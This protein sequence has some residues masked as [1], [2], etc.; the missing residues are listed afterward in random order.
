L[1]RHLIGTPEIADSDIPS[2]RSFSPSNTVLALGGITVTFPQSLAL[3]R[4]SPMLALC[5][6]KWD[7]AMGSCFHFELV[8]R[9]LAQKFFAGESV[10]RDIADGK[11]GD[12]LLTLLFRRVNFT[13]AEKTF[14]PK[15]NTLRN[16]LIHCEPDGV[17]R[18][19][20]E[21]LPGLNPKSVVQQ[22][23]FPPASSGAEIL[24]TIQTQ[25]GAVDVLAT[26]SRSDGFLG[27]MLQAAGDGT[28]DHATTILR[29]GLTIVDSK[30]DSE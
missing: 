24:E 12:G 27:W 11:K 29:H 3:Y 14:L 17:L 7:A 23:R 20:Q 9:L 19:V 4:S 5:L 2:S 1:V 26:T 22:L 10:T 16:K 18:I 13:E 25:K 21:L 28:F 30:S 8:V 15:C 6:P